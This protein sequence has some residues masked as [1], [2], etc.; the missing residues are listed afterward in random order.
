M[1]D[2]LRPRPQ[3]R[4]HRLCGFCTVYP[5]QIVDLDT[6]RAWC[7]GCASDLFAVGDPITCYTELDGSEEYTMLLA[8]HNYRR[9]IT[10]EKAGTPEQPRYPNEDPRYPR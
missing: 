9:R 5:A 10:A 4:H 3:G 2:A 1:P 8:A 7:V 6:E